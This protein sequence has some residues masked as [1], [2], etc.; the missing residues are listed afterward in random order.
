MKHDILYFRKIQDACD[1]QTK[2]QAQLNGLRKRISRDFKQPLNW[3]QVEVNGTEQ[4]LL[5]MKSTETSVKKI[6]A[7]PGERLHLGDLIKWN[8]V[9]WLIVSLDADHQVQYAGTMKQCNMVLRWQMPDR[10]IYETYAVTEDATKYGSGVTDT[11]LMRIGEFSLKAKVQMND[12]TLQIKRDQR[13]LV[14]ES[15]ALHEP[16]AYITSRINQVTGTYVTVENGVQRNY[17]YIEV[18]MLEDQ[19]RPHIDRADLMIADYV[20]INDQT[21]SAEGTGGVGW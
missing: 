14:G 15:S 6:E 2:K 18:T 1:A 13:F 5:V 19:F 4:D 16:N 3:E 7:R 21:D 12:Y 17:G 20:E 11:T 10:S 9:F 8:D